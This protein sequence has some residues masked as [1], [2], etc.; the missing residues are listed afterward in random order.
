L[1]GNRSHTTIKC[2]EFV[3][4]PRNVLERHR[5]FE[6]L[7]DPGI[8]LAPKLMTTNRSRLRS[9]LSRSN[10]AHS[11]RLGPYFIRAL[12]VDHN[13]IHVTAWAL[14]FFI[15]RTAH[16]TRWLICASHVITP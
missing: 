14:L 3:R 16:N 5:R 15:P 2:G 12:R 11:L 1:L 8:S 7:I 9:L 4:A 13:A 10:I 6:L